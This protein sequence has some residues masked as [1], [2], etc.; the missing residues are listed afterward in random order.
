MAFIPNPGL[1]VSCS[2]PAGQCQV[3]DYNWTIQAEQEWKC[4]TEQCVRRLL[5]KDGGEIQ[6][7]TRIEGSE[8]IQLTNN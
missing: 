7:Q 3:W 4:L 2:G 6:T 1:Q 5:H 8:M